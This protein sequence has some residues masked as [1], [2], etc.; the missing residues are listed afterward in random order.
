VLAVT[1]ADARIAVERA[2]A[3]RTCSSESG[4]PLNTAEPQR[5]QNSFGLPSGGVNVAS[6]SSPCNSSK[7]CCGTR[8]LAEEPVPV[9]R[10]QR[11]QW[12]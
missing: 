7:P 6:T 3:D 11:V 8:P 4:S 1:R 12:Q 2:E 5:E 10:W 9:R